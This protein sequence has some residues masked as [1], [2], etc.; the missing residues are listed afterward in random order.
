MALK[1]G[2]AVQQLLTQGLDAAREVKLAQLQ[3]NDPTPYVTGPNGER[4]PVGGVANFGASI[5]AVPAWVWL[6]GLAAVGGLV[7]L[8]LLKR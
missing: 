5:A 4:V 3:V 1:I 8:P 7:V 6:L 2:E